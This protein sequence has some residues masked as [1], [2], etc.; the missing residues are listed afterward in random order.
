MFCTEENQQLSPLARC[1]CVDDSLVDALYPDWAS[2]WDKWQAERD[3]M[4][5][6]R[7]HGRALASVPEQGVGRTHQ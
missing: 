1:E 3:G 5:N 7:R 2:E 6:L 4:K